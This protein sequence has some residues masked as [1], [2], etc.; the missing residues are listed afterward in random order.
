MQNLLRI[1]EAASLAFHAMTIFAGKEGGRVSNVEIAKAL[2]ASEHTLSKVLQ[3]LA[4]A[5]LIKSYR[6]PAGG[7]VLAEPA[8]KITLLEVFEAV[9][10]PIGKAGCL[11]GVP[12][13]D[14]MDCVL[15]GLLVS[16]HEQVKNYFANTTLD[17]IGSRVN[18]GVTA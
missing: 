14:G 2:G 10:G 17:Q 8:S 5:G 16:V 15:G 4:R 9:E 18:L 13:C 12:A 3:R 7:F 6:G 11:L 1:S